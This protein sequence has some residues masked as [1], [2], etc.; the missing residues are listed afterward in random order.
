[1]IDKVGGARQF[2]GYEAK[3]MTLRSL[4]YVG[5]GSDQIGDWSRFAGDVLGMQVFE[6]SRAGL[7]FRMDDRQQRLFIDGDIAPGRRCFG[8]EV[9]DDAALL[10]VALAAERE[11]HAVTLESQALADRRHVR[12]LISLSDPVGNR[13]EIFHGAELTPTPF[14]PGRNISGFR[15]GPL[16][17]GHAVL[18]VANA[19]PVIA[20]Y[21]D[22]LGFKLSDF[23]LAPFKAFFFHLNPRHHSLAIIET[24]QDGFHHLMVELFNLDDVGQGY[25]LA[26]DKDC[27]G[28]TLG[29][30]TNDWMTSFYARTPSDF[31][32]E[33]G[34]G[35][36]IIDVPDWT[37]LEF[38]EGPSLWGHERDWLSPAQRAEARDLRM[39]AAAAGLRAPVQV[40]PG[41]HIVMPG[42]CAAWDGLLHAAG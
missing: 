33:Y 19:A 20:F 3:R 22:V 16:G 2:E 41:N 1:M 32:I 29:R 4:G 17:L 6:R 21:Q 9:A 15:T 10:A 23:M 34:W 13:L 28:V 26:L 24:G 11:G 31:M 5:V 12:G 35:G 30:H 8:W 38:T 36:R 14:S 37:P 7:A 39:D 18:T 27:V 25:D 42:T 40:L